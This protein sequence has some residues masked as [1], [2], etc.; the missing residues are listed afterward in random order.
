MDTK[1]ITSS[2]EGSE[3][4]LSTIPYPFTKYYE[5]RLYDFT[6]HLG[7]WFADEVCRQNKYRVLLHNEIHVKEVSQMT[8]KLLPAVSGRLNPVVN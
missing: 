6:Y 2:C 5:G 7:D 4:S 8:E 3:N 1:S